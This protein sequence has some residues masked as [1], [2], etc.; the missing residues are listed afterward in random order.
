MNPNPMMNAHAF[1]VVGSFENDV[2][3]LLLFLLFIFF[4]H[5]L[6]AFV[7]QCFENFMVSLSS[8]MLLQ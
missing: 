7:M 1:W 4:F 8:P 5:S 2:T 6:T 3:R